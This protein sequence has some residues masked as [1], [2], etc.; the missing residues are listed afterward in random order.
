MKMINIIT[1]NVKLLLLFALNYYYK[2]WL[3]GYSP[4][5]FVTIIVIILRIYY[6]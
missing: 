2:K 4:P 1:I 5:C 3:L 6:Y